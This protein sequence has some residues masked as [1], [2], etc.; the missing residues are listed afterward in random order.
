MGA[1]WMV[2]CGL[3]YWTARNSRS[4]S[5]LVIWTK[6]EK[7]MQNKLTDLNNHLFEQLERLMDDD[8][9]EEGL[10]KEIKRSKAVSDIAGKIIEN[11]DV[12][13]RAIKHADEYGYTNSKTRVMPE[14]LGVKN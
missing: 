5:L 13:L 14:L 6:G 2:G 8:L 12:Q 1:R 10:T 4:I 11:A 9:T 7:K 3:A